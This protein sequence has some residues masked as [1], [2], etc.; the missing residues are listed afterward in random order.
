MHK[1]PLESLEGS[2]FLKGSTPGY[3]AGYHGVSCTCLVDSKKVV[4]IFILAEISM[5]GP[6]TGNYE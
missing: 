5:L 2:S 6:R 4:M 3:H 1:V